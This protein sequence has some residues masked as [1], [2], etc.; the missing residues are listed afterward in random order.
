M[1]S[2][3][4]S[5]VVALPGCRFGPWLA[6]SWQVSADGKSTTFE[7]RHDVS[8][9]DGTRFDAKAVK[10][11]LDRI[12]D[13]KNALFAAGDVGSLQSVSVIGGFSVRLD[14][15]T[16]FAPLSEQLSKTNFGMI[17]PA[18][19]ATYGDQIPAHPVGTG[20]FELASIAPGTEVVLG[21]VEP[22]P[23]TC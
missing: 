18:A 7:L 16:P 11:N 9:H 1:R 22:S 14:F 21:R 23:R 13:P 4:D 17:S 5:L 3:F 6:T 19:L 8:F 20:P 2:I 12:L 10:A 15:A